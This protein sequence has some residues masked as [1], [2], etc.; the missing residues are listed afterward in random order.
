MGVFALTVAVSLAV[1]SFGRICTCYKYGAMHGD[2][3]YNLGWNS[4]LHADA[5]NFQKNPPGY[6]RITVGEL[7]LLPVAAS[8]AAAGAGL[9]GA[10]IFLRAR[11]AW[12][13]LN[14]IG[15]IV[16]GSWALSVTWFP[17]FLGWLAKACVMNFGG[18][19]AYRGILPFF[20]GLVLGE[21]VIATLWAIVSFV[22]GVPCVSML[23]S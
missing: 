17:I 16:C 21:A 4:W 11:F 20:L 14:P 1:T 13:P 9:T 22:T 3:A 19:T 10:M 23:P 6:E 12:W 18:A 15:Y 5:V 7:K 2:T 8:H